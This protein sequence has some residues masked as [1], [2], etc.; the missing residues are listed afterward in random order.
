MAY[1]GDG[2]GAVAG[3]VVRLV[4]GRGDPLQPQHL[5]LAGHDDH[6]DSGEYMLYSSWKEQRCFRIKV[7]PEY[8]GLA[9]FSQH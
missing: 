4:R 1:R 7:V 6:G 2:G 3:G 9:R 8:V 5:L